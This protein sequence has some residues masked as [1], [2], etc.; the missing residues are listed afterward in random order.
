MNNPNLAIPVRAPAQTGL[1]D[2][3]LPFEVSALDLRGRIVRLGPAVDAILSNHDYPLPVA[4]LV[5]EAIVLTVMLGSA[6]KIR[7][8]FHPADPERRPGAHAGGRFH[9]ARQGARLRAL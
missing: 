7:R 4:K 6:L 2:T 1:D 9:L 5:G 8:P 3:I